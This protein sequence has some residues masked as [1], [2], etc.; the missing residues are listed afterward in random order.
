MR[1]INGGY[2][3]GRYEASDSLATQ[4]RIA[5]SSKTNPMSIKKDG[6]VYNRMTQL[7]V[8][9]LSRNMYANINFESDL[10][11][12]YAWDTAIVFI[13]TF[14]QSNYSNQ[15]R[16][17][18][19]L[20]KTGMVGD[21]QL[22]INDMAGNI[23]EWTTETSNNLGIP[24]VYRGGSYYSSSNNTNNRSSGSLS[25]SFENIGFRPLLYIIL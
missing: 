25:D 12:S 23:Y 5:S 3:I 11:N 16:L 1:K 20:S 7:Q 17:S 8:A 19:S 24:S 15:T 10:I 4:N 21:E 9:S 14:G 22:N 6:F 18:S 13:Q 2:Y